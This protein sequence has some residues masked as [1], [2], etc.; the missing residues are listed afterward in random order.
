MPYSVIGKIT[1]LFLLCTLAYVAGRNQ[2]EPGGSGTVN[3]FT[4]AESVL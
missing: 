2:V 4:G 3:D 1:S